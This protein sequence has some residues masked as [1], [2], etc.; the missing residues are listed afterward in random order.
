M[1]AGQLFTLDPWEEAPLSVIPSRSS[2]VLP[3]TQQQ[4]RAMPCWRFPRGE[5]D[6]DQ[7]DMITCTMGHRISS[8]GMNPQ[9]SGTQGM[10]PQGL[11][12][13][14]VVP[15][16]GLSRHQVLLRNFGIET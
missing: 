9:G 8:L 6:L 7:C 2:V 16:I 4:A 13:Q 14:L 1:G 10:G 11:G 5:L 12:T 3:Q 15:E